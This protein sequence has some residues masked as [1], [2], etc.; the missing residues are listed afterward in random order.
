ML[1]FIAVPTKG[2]AHQSPLLKNQLR[3]EFIRHVARLHE[4]FPQHTF[5]VPMIQDYALLKHMTVEATWEAWGHHCRTLINVSDEVWVLEYDGW[6]ESTGVKAEIATADALSKKVRYIVPSDIT[7]VP[8]YV[9]ST[10]T[11]DVR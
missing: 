9:P 4:Q 11:F 5:L 7:G 10:H 3:E 2:V 8:V 1:I 6:E